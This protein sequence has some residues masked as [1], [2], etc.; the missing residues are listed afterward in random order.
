M[1]A[2]RCEDW[3]TRFLESLYCTLVEGDVRDATFDQAARMQGY[4]AVVHG[5]SCSRRELWWNPP[6]EHDE[7]LARTAAWL[8][9]EHYSP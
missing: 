5:T 3:E 1:V 7:A 4:N 9:R 8:A 6:F 2:L